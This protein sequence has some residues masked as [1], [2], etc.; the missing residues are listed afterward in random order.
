MKKE[1]ETEIK[2]VAMWKMGLSIKEIVDAVD[3]PENEVKDILEDHRLIIQTHKEKTALAKYI[4][5]VW[6]QVNLQVFRKAIPKKKKH[7]TKVISASEI[8]RGYIW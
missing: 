8:P 7:E 4:T 5:E 3:L 6:P 1:K 2:I